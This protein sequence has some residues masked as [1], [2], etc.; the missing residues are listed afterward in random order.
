MR[1]G[2]HTFILVA[3]LSVGAAASS[4]RAL[5]PAETFVQQSIDRGIAVMKDNS[6]D[7]T[8]RRQQ[9]GAL[10]A[11]VLDTR[12]MA[13]FML[14]DVRENVPATDLD[15][16]AEAYKAFTVANYESQL[17]GYGGQTLKVTGSVERAPGDYIVNAIVVD[18]AM[19]NDP[20]PLPVAFRVADEASGKF[21]VVDAS[22]MGIWLG[23]AQRAEFGAYLSLHGGDVA[24]LSAHLQETA[25]K[26]SAPPITSAAH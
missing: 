16:Y 12:K 1:C 3:V 6:L 15:M 14:G 9:I 18:P 11:E 4:A 8:A 5:T 22:I 20:N 21:A 25:A 24:A 26:F 10:L 19:P 13:L 2:W 17:N 7:D 23:L